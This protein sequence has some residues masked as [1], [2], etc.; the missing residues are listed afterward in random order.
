MADCSIFA[1]GW[2]ADGGAALPSKSATHAR[3]HIAVYMCSAE[4]ENLTCAIHRR[5]VL[6]YSEM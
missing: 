3:R 2:A 6:S 5:M 4:M 1:P